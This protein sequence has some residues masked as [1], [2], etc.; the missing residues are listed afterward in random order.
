MVLLAGCATE[1]PEPTTVVSP[2]PVSES[3]DSPAPVSELPASPVVPSDD[4]AWAEYPD[5]LDITESYRSEEYSTASG[6]LLMNLSIA[7][8]SVETAGFEE[9]SDYYQ[10]LET[11]LFQT[12]EEMRADAEIMYS[13]SQ[14][15][16]GLFLP[17]SFTHNY[18]IER[19]G[20]GVLSVTRETTRYTGGMHEDTRIVCE[21]FDLSTGQR[22]PLFDW[23]SADEAE[24]K[25]ALAHWMTTEMDKDP[26]SY[27]A[28]REEELAEA[29]DP[30]NYVRTQEGLA[31]IFDPYVLGPYT[32]GVVR[33]D[34]PEED[35]AG[36]WK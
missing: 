4:A 19:N 24:V 12:G 17:Y 29:I 26:D 11:M 22:M 9:I 27:Y 14:E 20:D 25:A 1:T 8:P 2:P 30:L 31:L 3:F 32:T 13:D 10:D 34:I 36:L 6:A 33:F 15:Q 16:Q 7:V 18:T 5:T 21:T 23:F 28:F 35:L